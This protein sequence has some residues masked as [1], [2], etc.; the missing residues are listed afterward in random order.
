MIFKFPPRVDVKKDYSGKVR[1]IKKKLSSY[2]DSSFFNHMYNHFQN[3]IDSQYGIS[4]NFPWSCFLAFK[5]KFSEPLKGNVSSMQKK[6]FIDIINR[7]YNL[8]NDVSD[9]FES[10]KILLSFR[11]MIIN[12]KLYQVP[13]KLELNTLARQYYWYC[14]YDG[15]YFEKVFYEANGITLESYYRMSAYFAIISCIDDGKE[16]T[17]IPINVYLIHLVPIFGAEV[18]KKYLNLVS[19]KWNELRSFMSAFRDTEQREVEYY[20]DPPMMMK[21]LVLTDEG[22]VVLSKHLLR[23]SL[24]SLVPTLLK[25][26]YGSGYKD[27]FGKVMESYIGSMLNELS[28]PVIPE[29]DII[30]LYKKHGLQAKTKTVDFLIKE[31]IGTVYIDSKA[32]EPDK[33]V[34]HSNSANSIKDRLANSFIKGV[35]QGMDCAYNVDKINGKE[36]CPKDS[37][38]IITHMDH[39]IPTGKMIEEVLDDSFFKM[40]EIKYGY[41]P[42]DKNRIY[43]VT[44]DEFEFLIEVCREK[45]ISITSI[46][47]ACS[48]SDSDSKTQKFN[49]MMHL[50]QLSPD[51]ISDRSMLTEYREYLFEDLIASMEKSSTLWDGRVELYLATRR[52]LQN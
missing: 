35:I 10:K 21:P 51:G 44:V 15:G 11:R 29:K 20:L 38:I 23:A 43:Y 25:S 47:D 46:I 28:K 2:D 12:Q 3:I 27:R 42:I 7:V 5:W 48:D 33:V 4:S 26:G 41:L 19:V 39:Y 9:L 32:I 36:K 24:A 34:K 45:E 52:Y 6:D 13:M 37:L 50:H 30:S 22:V 8:Q 40:F 14:N 31:E 49:V 17:Y 16:S 1:A 18:V